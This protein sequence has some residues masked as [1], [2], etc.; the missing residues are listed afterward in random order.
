M[1]TYTHGISL[2]KQK[3]IPTDVVSDPNKKFFNRSI[4]MGLK[5]AT[6]ECN[7]IRK[8]FILLLVYTN[9]INFLCRFSV[10]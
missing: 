3:H 4:H 2:E 6:L 5:F 7:E 1:H 10:S 9:N 8:K